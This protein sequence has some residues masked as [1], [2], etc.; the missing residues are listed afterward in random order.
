MR[1]LFLSRWFPYPPSN[2]SK[3]RVLAL[4][5]GLAQRH[6]VTLLSFVDQV[7]AVGI[8]TAL[9]SL[10]SAVETVPW[11]EFDPN[12][13]KA[14][15]GLFSQVPR[16]VVDTYSPIMEKRIR[17]TIAS[18]SYDVVVASQLPSAAYATS[19]GAVPAILEE[20]EVGQFLP[21]AEVGSSPA[22]RVRR[23]LTWAKYRHYVRGLLPAFARCTVVSEKEKQLVHE[24]APDYAPVNV[25]P[26]CVDVASYRRSAE[27]SPRDGVIFS[28]SFRYAANH[29]AVVWYLEHVHSDVLAKFPEA[30]LTVTGDHANLPLPAVQ[31]V[32]MTGYVDDVRSLIAGSA[33]SIVPILEGGGTRLKILEA[34]ALGTPVVSTSKGAEGLDVVDG[35]HL[36]IADT[37]HLFAEAVVRLLG[38]GGLRRRISS[39]A[40]DLVR[41]KYDWALVMPRFLD[42]VETV[43]RRE[44]NGSQQ[45]SYSGGLR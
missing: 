21:R 10:C 45:M 4:L 34:M 8:P 25:I 20:L 37:P 24:V 23:R 1:V 33:V 11:H 17:D 26:N 9:Q 13:R 43:A 42:L 39:D 19:F 12:S 14:R 22:G 40:Y 38:D 7:G 2:G 15:L 16:S 18:A 32:T 36:L 6:E 5:R 30:R 27:D 44:P 35:K 29:N 3:L 31:G 28:G 41:A